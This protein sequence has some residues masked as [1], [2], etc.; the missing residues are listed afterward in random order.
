MKKLSLLIATFLII[1]LTAMIPEEKPD[2]QEPKPFDRD[3]SQPKFYKGQI[4]IKVKEEIK[5]LP[6]QKGNVVF[7]IPSLDSKASKYEVDLLEK[8]FRFNPNRMKSG[9]PDLSRIYRIEFPVNYSVTKV[10]SEFSKDPNIEYAEPIPIIHPLVIPNDPM[11]G[12]LH[13]LTQIK[14]DSAWEIHK[15]ENG[16]EDIIIAIVDSGTEWDHEDLVDNIWQNLGEDIDSDGRTI[17]FIGGEWVLDPGDENGVDDDGNGYIDDFIGWNFYLNNNDPNPIPGTFSWQ[18]GTLM[19]GYASASTNN[20]VGIA[21]ISWNLKILP[22]QAGWESEVLQSYNAMIYAA[23]NGADVITNSWGNYDWFS[24][25]NYEAVIYVKSL[26]S[27]ILGGAANSNQ[28]RLMYPAAYPGVLGVAALNNNNEKAY[29]SNYGPH[30]AISAP[31]GEG[32][33]LLKT[34]DVNNTYSSASGTSCATPI[35]AGLLGLVKS[36]HPEWT[37]DQVITQVLSTADTI[38]DINPGFENLLGAGCINAFRALDE[39]GVTLQQEIALDLFFA[40]FQDWDGNHVAEEGDTISLSLKLINYNYGIG[41]DDAT[42]TLM[43]EDTDITIINDTYTGDIPADDYFTMENAFEFII[44]EQATTHFADLKLI[45][46]ADKEIT[47]GD[48][49]SIEILIEPSGILVYQ[50]EGLGN[51]YSGDLIYEFLYEKGFDVLYTSSF[52]SSL[53]GFDAVFLSFGNHGMTLRE[54]TAVS[55]KMTQIIAEYIYQGGRIYVECGSFFGSQSFFGYPD[56]AEIIDLFGINE[57]HAPVYSNVITNLSGMPNS[58][59]HDLIFTASTQNLNW[60]IDVMVPNEHGIEALE[61]DNYGTVA[62]QGEGEYGQK[63]FAFSYALAKLVD[64]EPPNVRDTVLARIVN[65]F[66]L[67]PETPNNFINIPGDY[68]TI[69][70]GIDVADNGD[71]ILVAPGTYVE[72]INYN[73]KNITVAS[74]YLT[75][76]EPSY[77]SQTVIDGDSISSVVTFENGEDSTAV[78]NGFTLTNGAGTP[79]MGPFPNFWGTNGGGLFIIGSHPTIKNVCIKGN[80]ATW[81]GGIYVGFS[82]SPKMAGIVV[83]ENIARNGGGLYFNSQYTTFNP[84]NRCN[85]YENY[86]LYGND[87]CA[88]SNIEIVAD[89]FSVLFPTEYHAYPIENFE[90]DILNGMIEQEN[91]DLFVSPTGDNSHSGLSTNEPLKNIRCAFSKILADETNPHTIYIADGIYGPDATGEVYLLNIPNYVSLVGESETGTILDGEWQTAVIRTISNTGSSIKNMTITHG[92][93]GSESTGGSTAPYVWAGGITLHEGSD[94]LVENIIVTNNSSGFYCTSGSSPTIENVTIDANDGTGLYCKWS[95]NATVSNTSITNNSGSGIVCSGSDPILT[96]L[97]ITGNTNSG[98]WCYS[99]S[100]V[101]NNVAIINNSAYN[102]GGMRCSSGN[103]VSYPSLENVTIAYNAAVNEGGGIYC[104]TSAKPIFDTDNRCNIYLNEAPL[105]SDYYAEVAQNVV[106]DTFTVMNPSSY[107]AFPRQFYEFDILNSKTEL[108]DADLYVSTDGDNSNS[109]LS[110]EEPLKNIE[111]AFSRIIAD[112]DHQN[113]IH[114]LEG[115]YS[116]STTDEPFPVYMLDYVN[117]KGASQE[118]VI[119]D[120]EGQS[121][122]LSIKNN[123]SNHI[124]NFSITGGD[125][126]HS[127]PTNLAGGISIWN[128]SVKL[129]DISVHDNTSGGISILWVS[130]PVLENVSVVNNGDVWRGGGIYISGNGC[131]PVLK[132]VLIAEN[133]AENVAGGVYISSHADPKFINVTLSDNSA[134]TG[135]GGIYSDSFNNP[136]I[137]NSIIWDN[138]PPELFG[139]FT[140]NYSNIQGGWQGT[141]NIDLDPLFSVNGV[142][143]FSLQDES[144]CINTGIPDT[145]GLNLPELDLAGNPR[146]YGGRIEMGAYENQNIIIGVEEFDV[147]SSVFEVRCYPNPFQ[148][149]TTICFTLPK[150]G[151]VNLE[152]HDITGNKTETLLTG[153]LQKGEHSFVWESERMNEGLYLLSLESEGFLESRKLLKME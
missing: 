9:M 125:W 102:G 78:L 138:D 137:M 77:I 91:A 60:F 67:E 8:R 54:G 36:Y 41:T 62:I 96:D 81:G 25:S 95:C 135:S 34:T 80:S 85:I 114:L 59:C 117:L 144:P 53:I 79:Y 146:F 58:L 49:I 27:I 94:L 127:N 89:T 7:N 88:D 44:S 61:E 82:G 69:Q 50:G 20:N 116:T 131:N 113:T 115:I 19:G 136:E 23:E 6:Q 17:E 106:V 70:Q 100:P 40:D 110:E 33:Y 99:S 90:F 104:K 92:Q 97:T 122:V 12:D 86:A 87:L 130:S 151:F 24:Q 52:P 48:T 26:G 46:I 149:Q 43:T 29:Y 57:T 68:P 140:I 112:A 152:I 14:A 143:P 10:A 123:I 15:G 129:K 71:T 119:L 37:S 64:G 142:H 134:T 1:S 2:N 105:G 13:H 103:T 21:S 42:F 109:G 141:G 121:T 75:T 28:T 126:N 63:T 120:A 93:G 56:Y 153:Y 32:A 51:A 16:P 118:G 101:L 74:H 30:I 139:T 147:Q 128:S 72:N 35:I 66:E 107:Q 111:Y 3:N 150:A 11:F 4:C 145:T 84:I 31:G 5:D 45:T 83:T 38:D 22:I 47:W 39:S 55:M 73:G 133:Q 76:N 132:N 18:H 108:I 124:S 98:I 65:F 148:N